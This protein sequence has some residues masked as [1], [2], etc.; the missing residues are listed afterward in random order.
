MNTNKAQDTALPWQTESTSTA[1]GC[2]CVLGPRG[3]LTMSVPNSPLRGKTQSCRLLGQSLT[4]TWLHWD[5]GTIPCKVRNSPW[6]ANPV[7]CQKITTCQKNTKLHPIPYPKPPSSFTSNWPL[8]PLCNMWKHWIKSLFSTPDP[9]ML[10]GSV[11]TNIQVP[12][13]MF[14]WK[15]KKP[16]NNKGYFHWKPQLRQDRQQIPGK[17]KAQ[18][19]SPLS[20]V[21]EKQAREDHC[22]TLHLLEE[23]ADPLI[24]TLFYYFTLHL[25]LHYSL[26][27]EKGSSATEEPGDPAHLTSALLNTAE[28]RWLTEGL[29]M[30]SALSRCHRIVNLGGHAEAS[31]NTAPFCLVLDSSAKALVIAQRFKAQ[32]NNSRLCLA[33]EGVKQNHHP[34]TAQTKQTKHKMQKQTRGRITLW[35]KAS[36]NIFPSPASLV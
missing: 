34:E 24:I 1:G 13:W 36:C 19:T 35:C 30:I 29:L 14:V 2:G 3:L 8:L 28:A 31:D 26:G 4:Q 11:T 17:R 16:C 12:S 15:K 22:Q 6:K 10:Q 33:G 23:Q 32:Q 20:T 7:Q 27:T 21:E 9:D 18:E 25:N 5:K